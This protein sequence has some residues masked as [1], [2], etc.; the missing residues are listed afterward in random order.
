MLG[1]CH[2][3][4]LALGFIYNIPGIRETREV[5]GMKAAFLE[6]TGPPEVIGFGDLPRPEPRPGEILV[7]VQA[8]ALNPIDTYIRAGMTAMQLP[9][10]FI[11]GCDLSGV[12]EAVGAGVKGFQTGDRVWGSNQ[13]L[14][15]RQG[16]CAEYVCAAEDWFYPT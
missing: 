15:G 10:P 7:R 8:A 2:D 1:H 3:F 11:T 5:I 14:L 12:V 4:T 13:G 16:T 9:M 6:R